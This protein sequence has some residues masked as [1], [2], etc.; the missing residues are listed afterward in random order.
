[1]VNVMQS[2]DEHTYAFC[3]ENAMAGTKYYYKVRAVGFCEEMDSDDGEVRAKLDRRTAAKRELKILSGYSKVKSI[4][5]NLPR[6][7]VS[8]MTVKSSGKPKL[9]WKRSLL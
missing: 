1:L 7:T 5:C 6:P 4:V 2:S 3:D 8:I 9:T